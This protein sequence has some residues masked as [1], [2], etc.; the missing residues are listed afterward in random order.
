MRRL[1]RDLHPVGILLLLFLYFLLMKPPKFK[2]SSD[3]IR[4][5]LQGKNTCKCE[6]CRTEEISASSINTRQNQILNSTDPESNSGLIS[7]FHINKNHL[8]QKEYNNKSSNL[9]KSTDRESITF[10][11]EKD[12]EILFVLG[13][14][15]LVYLFPNFRRLMYWLN[16]K[17]EK[18]DKQVKTTEKS[19][20]KIRKYLQK[21]YANKNITLSGTA[22]AVGLTN[23]EVNTLLKLHVKMS[24]QQ[25]INCSRLHEAQRLLRQSDL[26]VVEISSLVGYEYV[27][28]FNRLFKK[29]VGK[30]PLEYRKEQMK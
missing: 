26:N 18:V 9:N 4:V 8:L 1:L 14:L 13:G 23:T 28:S 27:N 2:L 10:V 7:C 25:F 3:E 30:T 12:Y 29:K 22:N 16:V 15:I 5:L 20:V 6:T 21:N 17:P 11:Q 24:F 19:F